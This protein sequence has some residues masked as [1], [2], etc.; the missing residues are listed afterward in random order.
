MSRAE[1]SRAEQSRTEKRSAADILSTRAPVGARCGPR[2]VIW[3]ALWVPKC[4]QEHI[5]GARNKCFFGAPK[6]HLSWS[7]P[8][9]FGD[10]FQ[11]LGG[12][13]GV[14]GILL[15]SPRAPS[16][17]QCG[18]RGALEFSIGALQHQTRH[19]F[20]PKHQTII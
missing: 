18:T 8:G 14:S 1:Q 4:G 15:W 20:F 3:E 19:V 9:T 7:L 5:F 6:K 17:L 16:S 13:P 2:G 10:P 11:L 12:R